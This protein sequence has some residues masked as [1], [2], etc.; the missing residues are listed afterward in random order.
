LWVIVA[1]LA[2]GVIGVAAGFWFGWRTGFDQGFEEAELF[3]TD[4]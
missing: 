2:G 3:Y 1:A 4:Q